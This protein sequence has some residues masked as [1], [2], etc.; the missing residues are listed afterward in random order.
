VLARV[1]G[2]PGVVAAGYTTAVPLTRKGGANGLSLEGRDNGP[3][4]SW[5]ANHRQ[6]SADYFRAMGQA[7]REGRPFD[8]RDDAGAVP[9][10]A[11]N[12]TMARAFWPGESAVGK[13][14][15]VGSP[16]SPDPWLTVVAVVADV[17]QMGADAPVKPEMY[18]P[19]KQAAPHWA[20][21]PYVFFAPRDL[22][23]RT[24][25][26]PTSIV[27]PVREAVREVD[28]YQPVSSV[29]TMEE[30]LGRETA[31][32]RVGVILLAGFAGL[33]LLLAAL[34]VYGV[35]AFFVVQHTPEIGVRVALGASPGDVLRMVVAR[36]MKLVLAGV[37]LGLAGALALTRLMESQLYGV[38]AADPLTFLLTTLLLATVAL[39]ACLVPALRATRVDPLEALRYE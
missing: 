11:V 18:V 6:V 27:A 35:L 34:G 39:L 1:K 8:E 31:E 15:K 32:R 25:V 30:V 12:E 21:G 38:S 20:N 33:A 29:R 36:G 4:A 10:A 37:A 23:V 24:S 19:Y 7:V 14:F 3:N 17:R 16:D 13:R 28:P 9:V 2:L 5:N 22:V 26:A